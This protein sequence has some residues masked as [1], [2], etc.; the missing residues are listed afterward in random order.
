MEDGQLVSMYIK[1]NPDALDILVHRYKDR[2]YGFCYHLTSNKNEAE[3]LFQETWLKAVDKVKYYDLDKKFSTWIYTIAL[4]LYRDNYR[5]AKRWL[6]K[7]RLIFDDGKGNS[8]LDRMSSEETAI[9]EQVEDNEQK[10]ELVKII[11]GL[12]DNYRIPLILFYYK[13]MT[14]EEIAQVLDIPIGTVKSRLNTCKKVL[15]E[16][17]EARSFGKR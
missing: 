11:N 2:L 14:Y 16:E 8:E 17:M 6:S 13:E 3:D 4:N 7:V 1:G 10:R 9:S 12:K 5:K 15:R